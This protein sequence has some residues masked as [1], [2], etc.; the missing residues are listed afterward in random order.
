MSIRNNGN[1]N[2]LSDTTDIQT[3]TQIVNTNSDIQIAN[4]QNLQN[5]LNTKAETSTPIQEFWYPTKEHPTK[6]T[7]IISSPRLIDDLN[8][9]FNIF[10][11]VCRGEVSILRPTS[12]GLICSTYRATSAY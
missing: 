3:L 11:K 1:L 2:L 10:I 6:T 12:Y 8:N 5:V 7:K 4:V 9:V